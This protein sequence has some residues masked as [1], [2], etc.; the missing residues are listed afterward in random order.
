MAPRSHRPLGDGFNLPELLDE[1]A[2]HYLTRA[3]TATH[4]NKTQA[5]AL[6]GLASYQTLT[7]WLARYKVPY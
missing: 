7:N 3:M 1:V 6:V 2:H 4:G 5:A